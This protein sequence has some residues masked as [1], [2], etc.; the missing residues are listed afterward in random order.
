MA[1]DF[2][3]ISWTKEKCEKEARKYKSRAEFHLKSPTAYRAGIKHD[4]LK[5][6]CK[7]MMV[8]DNRAHQRQVWN[9]ESY[10]KEGK[11]YE[12]KT[13]FIKGSPGAY[14][15][16]K[17]LNCV[18][19]ATGHLKVLL[20]RHW[21]KET[22]LAEAKKY[23]SRGAFATQSKGAYIFSGRKGWRKEICAHMISNFTFWDYNSI[24]K[25]AKK[26]KF[27]TEFARKSGGGYMYARDKG[28]L[29]DI[30]K[31]MKEQGN[32]FTRII[33]SFEFADNCVYVGLTFNEK[34]RKSEHLSDNRGPVAKHIT[35]TGLIPKYKRLSNPVIE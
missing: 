35:K 11:K 4:W 28:I 1:T 12:F 34:K 33:Y 23:T 26:Y 27:R 3:F 10:V 29:D 6:L 8:P 21:T 22:C 24:K 13:D 5:E 9:R 15:A 32:S 2:R 7:H 16:C 18:K 14:A 25:E 17:R 31:H 19:E 20:N 30:C